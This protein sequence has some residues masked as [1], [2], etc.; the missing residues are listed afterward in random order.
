MHILIIGKNGNLGREFV[1]YL[2]NE[3][4][5][6]WDRAEIDITN[7]QDTFKKITDV[8]PDIV[9]NCAAYTAVDLGEINYEA[10]NLLNGYGPGYIAGACKTVGATMVHFSTGMVFQGDDSSGYHE[11]SR[12]DPVNAYGKTKL[13]GEELVKK[14]TDNYYI[15]RTE[16]LY[17][18]PENET[19]KKSFNEIMLDLAALGGPLKGVHDEIG[20][21]TWAKDLTA[22]TMNIIKNG[23]ASGVYHLANSGQA[24][25][26]EWAQAIMEIKQIEIK[27]ELVSGSAFPRPAKRPQF[28]LLNNTKLPH[29]RHWKTALEEY[30]TTN[31]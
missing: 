26:L 6:A 7:E 9:I 21:P 5:T 12:P 14:N 11:N 29:M 18:R 28:E 2:S 25:R 22:S 4:V 31:L 17:A 23:T 30:L 8:R 3:K 10:A 20:K 13:L 24:S 16:W 27:F 19:A 1:K 15:I